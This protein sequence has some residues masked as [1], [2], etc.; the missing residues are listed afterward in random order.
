V[1]PR[2][3]EVI[4][5]PQP[6][7]IG[8]T[9]DLL[10]R[11]TISNARRQRSAR[12]IVRQ[13]ERVPAPGEHEPQDVGGWRS[14]VSA[15]ALRQADHVQHPQSSIQ[16]RN[17]NSLSVPILQVRQHRSG[18]PRRPGDG[19]SRRGECGATAKLDSGDNP[20]GC[21]RPNSGCPL[22]VADVCGGQSRETADTAD[23]L[24]RKVD[25]VAPRP[26]CPDQDSDDLGIAQCVAAEAP[27][28]LSGS[29]TCRQVGDSQPLLPHP[30]RVW[31][32]AIISAEV[33][34]PCG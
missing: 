6:T 32:H 12:V 2:H 9:P 4:E 13:G 18:D 29:L 22:D 11:L 10:G 1:L 15:R 27:Q 20:A 31:A 5:E 23:Q 3:D 33:D 26:S 25:G 21:C 16:D 17:D 14:G 8:G 28:P 7:R 34:S 24:V 30:D 19:R